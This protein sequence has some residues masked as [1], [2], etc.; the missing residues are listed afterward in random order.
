MIDSGFVALVATIAVGTYF[1]TVT[2]FGL[3]MIVMGAAGAFALAPLP[4]VAA[5]IGLVTLVNSAVVLHGRL[6]LVD[7]PAA[8]AILVGVLPATV[9]GVLLLDYLS[10]AASQTIKVLLGTTIAAS[11]IVFALRPTQLARRSG[12]ASFFASGLFAGLFGG[13]FGMA[14]PP[15]IFHFYRQPMSLEAVR[16]MLLLVFAC[17]SASRT[18]F[19]GMQGGLTSQVWLLAGVAVLFAALS[20]VLGRRYPPPL[21]PLAMRRVAYLTLI[22]IGVGLV[23]STLGAQA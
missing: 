11:G 2:G 15:V 14:G 21:A 19:V 20:A 8:R 22:L 13:L 5:V 7:W 9:A 17:T 3:G 10:S 6:A 4:E 18:A 16:G 23:G 12:N 1:Q